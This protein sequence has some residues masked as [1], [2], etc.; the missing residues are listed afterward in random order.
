METQ[1]FH[2][3]KHILFK[4]SS[5]RNQNPSRYYYNSIITNLKVQHK[6]KYIIFQKSSYK[7]RP[8]IIYYLGAY[9]NP[10]SY[11]TL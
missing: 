6:P 8:I 9:K 1:I 2:Q 10:L 7:N 4:K 3:R 11:Y 5:K